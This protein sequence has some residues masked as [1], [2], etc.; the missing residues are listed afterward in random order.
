VDR[1]VGQPGGVVA[2]GVATGQPEDAL[3]QQIAQ[4][5]R[6][7]AGLAPVAQGAGQAPRQA[8]PVV[9]RLQQHRA[10]V[11]AGARLIEPSDDRLRNPVEPEGRLR[12]TVCGHRA[13]SHSCIETPEHRFYSTIEGLGGPVVFSFVNFPGC[14][15]SRA[16]LLRVK[17]PPHPR[18]GDA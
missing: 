11:G 2:V 8:E 9:D 5:V 12:Y 4:R 7:L 14:A 15:P 10:A 17:V 3:A 1:V 6:H 18:R 16:I 13:S